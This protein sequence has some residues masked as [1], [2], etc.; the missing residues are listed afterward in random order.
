MSERLASI[1]LGSNTF[2][3]SIGRVVRQGNCAQVYTEDHLRELVAMADGLDEH[4]RL[5]P[6][7]VE[8]ALATLHRFGE[9]LRD[10][11]PSHVRCVAT[12]TFR[13]ARNAAEILPAAERALGFPI[14][15]ISGL[16]EARLIYLGVI[17]DL[18]PTNRHRLV[19]DIGGG[20][21]EFIIGRGKTP[22]QLASLEL[23]CTTLTRRFFPQGRITEARMQQAI[24]AARMAI[25][26]IASRYRH[27][28]WQDAYGSSGTAKGLLAILRGNG[29][30]QTG[31]T[32]SGMQQ[33]RAGLVRKGRV[34]L[35]DWDGLKPERV[36]VLPGGLAIMIAAF[37]ELGIDRMQTGDGALRTGVLQDLLGRDQHQDQRDETVRQFIR[38]YALDETQAGNVCRL[39]LALFDQQ[40]ANAD[41]IQRLELR[42]ALAW[43]ARLHEVGLAISRHDYH[44]HTAYILEH[45]DMPG[46]S[47]DDQKLLAFLAL[48]HQGRL[49][50]VRTYRPDAA[51]WL[52]LLCLRLAV[53]FL[54]R[55][56]ATDIP[57][58]SL[59]AVYPQVSMTLDAQWLAERPLTRFQLAAETRI[60]H[61]VGITLDIREAGAQSMPK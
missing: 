11:P 46:F 31:I 20:S 35:E 3:L 15:I 33:L 16:E 29:L 28:G 8:Q 27:T 30:S 34:R 19:I 57:A 60:W 25:V 5:R 42:R 17:H 24:L 2:R 26:G 10:F 54:R 23:G 53:L 56:N 39:A 36:S 22:V 47:H 9:R 12:N 51:R 58:V 43:A 48:G 59:Q 44:K 55:R 13:V 1:D 61:K 50:K 37:H 40:A 52:A 45:A 38:R 32:A 41:A 6:A 49:A 18:P 21:T 14:E 7:A 4:Q